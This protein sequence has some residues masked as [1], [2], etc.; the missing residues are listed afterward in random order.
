MNTLNSLSKKS[1]AKHCWSLECS[2]LE[3]RDAL[4]HEITIAITVA[5]RKLEAKTTVQLPRQ[6]STVIRRT[7]SSFPTFGDVSKSE[8]PHLDQYIQELGP[9]EFDLI[10]KLII[11]ESHCS[12][13]SIIMRR[14]LD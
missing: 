11:R 10:N 6:R 4:A 2:Q 14:H 5:M 12:I 8:D 7:H 3:Y 13:A 9:S 1:G